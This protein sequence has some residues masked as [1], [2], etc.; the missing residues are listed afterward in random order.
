MT[1]RDPID[2]YVDILDAINK[3]KQK[4]T[5]IMYKAN[6]TWMRLKKYL[7]FLLNNDYLNQKVENG[8]MV[9]SLT[10]KG[11]VFFEH[12]KKPSFTPKKMKIS[13][14]YGEPLTFLRR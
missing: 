5:H 12:I 3:G 8:S 4:P 13:D 14:N 2:I 9:F 7:D 1:R 11:K 6:L 10:A